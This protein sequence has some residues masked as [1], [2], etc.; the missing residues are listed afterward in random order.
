MSLKK[1]VMIFNEKVKI[2]VYSNRYL[3]DKA[4]VINVYSNCYLQALS[5]IT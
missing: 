4:T 5:T 2:N 3:Q 1:R